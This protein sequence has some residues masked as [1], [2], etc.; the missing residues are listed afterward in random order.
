MNN[1]VQIVYTNVAEKDLRRLP[2]ATA[3]R[4]LKKIAENVERTDVFSR[5]KPLTGQFAGCYR[6]RVGDYRVIFIVDSQRLVTIVT[7]LNI[8][9]RRDVYR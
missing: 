3:I 6:Y 9:H 8:K 1:S 5:A 2:K 4:I 7:I